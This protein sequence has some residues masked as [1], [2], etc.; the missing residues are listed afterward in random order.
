MATA[1]PKA[2]P[3]AALPLLV[4]AVILVVAWL[5]LG[6]QRPMETPDWV[7]WSDMDLCQD[8]DDD[9][10]AET[11]RLH[12]G[13]LSIEDD[14][15]RL[16]Y[17]TPGEWRVS[18]AFTSEIDDN[19]GTDLLLVTWKRGNYGDAMPFWVEANDSEIGQHLFVF[20]YRSGTMKPVWMSSTLEKSAR[21]IW[22]DQDSYLHHEDEEGAETIWCWDYWGFKKVESAEYEK[23]KSGRATFLAVGDNII[24]GSLYAQMRIPESREFDFT[25]LYARV[26]DRIRSADIAAV[27]QETPLI[28]DPASYGDYPSFGTPFAVGAA[29]ANAGFDV[30]CA[31]TNHACDRGERGMRETMRFWKQYPAVS[32]VGVHDS[33]DVSTDA[34]AHGNVQNGPSSA[35]EPDN[36]QGDSSLAEKRDSTPISSSSAV[37]HTEKSRYASN[38]QPTIRTINGIRIALFDVTAV[39]NDPAPT[40]EQ[41]DLLDTLGDG[42]DV[43]RNLSIARDDSDL[44]VCFV[45]AGDEYADRPSSAQRKI[46][47]ML[48]DAGAD[49][50]ICSHPHVVYP[51]E[52]VTTKRGACGLVFWGLGNFASHQMDLRTILGAIATFTIVAPREP[53]Q[54]AT[55]ESYEIEPVVCHVQ[56]DTSAVYLLDDYTDELAA[57]HYAN[58]LGTPV[59]IKALREQWETATK[60]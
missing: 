51:V 50:V 22:L 4:A 10:H 36:A 17:R 12:G 59:T 38:C 18:D 28:E 42:R 55:V 24:H 25:P 48:L 35:G 31:A 44:T 15:G 37:K 19:P 14:Q 49:V 26:A 21:K 8:L 13:A 20:T 29:L 2:I 60:K 58:T 52:R 1:H 11:I 46:V 41:L 27:V 56:T 23:R 40:E 32:L 30:I 47:E 53:G 33:L 5:Q 45:H 57:E 16:R 3:P 7:H 54:R 34:T 6:M 9:G 39:L 43:S